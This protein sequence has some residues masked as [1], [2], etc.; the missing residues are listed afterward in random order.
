MASDA[1]RHPVDGHP[2][3]LRGARDP[4]PRRLD[5]VPRRRFVKSPS[6][7]YLEVPQIRGASPADYTREAPG[8]QWGRRAGPAGS[9]I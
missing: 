7:P 4:D 3:R 6:L 5:D 8:F 9:R 1:E 2:A